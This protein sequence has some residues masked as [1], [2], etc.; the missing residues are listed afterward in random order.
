MEPRHK[1]ELIRLSIIFGV[2]FTLGTFFFL[3]WLFALDKGHGQQHHE[4]G[5]RQLQKQQSGRNPLPT[6]RRFSYSHS[7]F[8]KTR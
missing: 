7:L 5:N 8:T 1:R 6:T 2:V 4:D 3:G